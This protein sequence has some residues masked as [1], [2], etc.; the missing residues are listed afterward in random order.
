[1]DKSNTHTLHDSKLDYPFTQVSTSKSQSNFL[2][3][4]E[5]PDTLTSEDQKP[6]GDYYEITTTTVST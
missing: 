5:K 1:M 2:E 4:R 3:A 6:E